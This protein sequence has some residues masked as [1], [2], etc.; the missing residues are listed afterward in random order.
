M[1]YLSTPTLQLILKLR[2]N[3]VEGMRYSIENPLV[4]LRRHGVIELSNGYKINFDEKNKTMI[5]RLLILILSSG[6]RFGEGELQ[7]KFDQKNGIVETHQGIK[8]SI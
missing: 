7:W 3:A 2:E 1:K 8:F 6:I 4:L 5:I